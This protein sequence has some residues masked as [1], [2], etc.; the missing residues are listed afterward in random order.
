[1][2]PTIRDLLERERV[3]RARA[4]HLRREA[5]RCIEEAEQCQAA[6]W[7]IQHQDGA[8]LLETVLSSS[9]GWA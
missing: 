9:G 5:G 4:R 8:D 7:R 6:A 2:N 3:L 1:M